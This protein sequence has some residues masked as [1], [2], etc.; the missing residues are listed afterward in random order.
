MARFR[1]FGIPVQIDPW[2]IL[3]LLFVY[4]YSGAQRVGLYAAISIGVLTLI[5]ELGHA[6]AARRFGC[7]VSVRLNLFV[8]WASYS[9]ERPLSR[10]Q[11]VIISLLGPLSQ[12]GVALVAM[13]VVHQLFQQAS[14]LGSREQLFDLWQGLSWAGVVIAL[15]NLLPLWPLDGGHVVHHLLGRWLSELAALRV[16]L[17]GSIA[18]LVG[19]V[20]LGVAAGGDGALATARSEGPQRAARAILDPSATSAL[21]TQVSSF[22]A[23]LLR[24]PWFLI[25][26]SGLLTFQTLQHLRPAGPTVQAPAD[27]SFAEASVVTAEARGWAEDRLPELPE[28]WSA[29]PWLRAHVALRRGDERG[30]TAAL[31]QVAAG[32]RRW[33]LPDPGRSEL[34]ELVARLPRPW[35]VGELGP[36]LVLARVLGAHAAPADLLDY[37]GRL[38]QQTGSVE[39]LI[40]AAGALARR[41]HPDDSMRWLER[42]DVRS[43][44]SAADLERS[45]VPPAPPARR[46][47][48]AGRSAQ[49]RPLSKIGPVAQ[50][51]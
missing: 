42:G 29:S 22:P 19:L 25:L 24:T 44:G 4:Q 31:A 8:G 41:G 30:V 33:V 46:F 51:S 34:A 23:H 10:R 50:E 16:V 38:Y 40:V 48:P 32:G 49:R 13:F 11:Q 35:P 39:P 1:L 36:S 9:S 18:G 20:I 21:W 2:F 28:G 14:E 3:G 17:Y 45:G 6:I 47:P 5:H 37:T 15:L 43:A 12:L 26:F 27:P 7:E